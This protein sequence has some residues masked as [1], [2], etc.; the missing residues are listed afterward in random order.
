MRGKRRKRSDFDSDSLFVGMFGLEREKDSEPLM[1]KSWIT[2]YVLPF[3]SLLI[4]AL[5]LLTQHA[6]VPTLAWAVVILYLL[7]AAGASLYAP[8]VRAIRWCV[9]QRSEARLATWSRSRLL[10][11]HQQLTRL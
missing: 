11:T 4:A 7:V 10:E 2:E 1:P 6:N 3:G 9:A 5:A 8:V